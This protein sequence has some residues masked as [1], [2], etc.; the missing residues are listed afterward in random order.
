LSSKEH[1]LAV[2]LVLHDLPALFNAEWQ[3]VGNLLVKL[4]ELFKLIE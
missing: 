1:G 2:L 3:M 4:W